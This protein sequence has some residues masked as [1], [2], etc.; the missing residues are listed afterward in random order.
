MSNLAY[1]YI[2]VYKLH[3]NF[4]GKKSGLSGNPADPL[5]GLTGTHLYYYDI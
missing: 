1:Y 4:V 2:K 5:Y 3:K